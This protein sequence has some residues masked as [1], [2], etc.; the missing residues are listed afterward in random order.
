MGADDINLDQDRLARLG[1]VEAVLC[2]H[3]SVDQITRILERAGDT[4][5]LLTCLDEAKW[6]ALPDTVRAILDYDPISATGF[7]GA[8]APVN[9][10]ARIAV[11]SAGTSDLA[12]TREAIRTLTFHG[13]DCLEIND[14]GVAGLNRLLARQD[15][16]AAMPVVI[17]VAGM[18]GALFSVL[19]G[20]VP[21]V[22]IA[23]PRSVGLGV[24]EGG[25][26]ALDSALASCAPGLVVVNIDNGY[27]AACAALRILGVRAG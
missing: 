26:V 5:L 16:I 12:V 22:I 15:E 20:L 19:G 23:V 14:V 18:E 7:Q 1:L 3:K 9:A 17:A 10:P 2:S 6:S 21:G 24:G 27:G 13:Q 11:V 4:R 25:R 8:R